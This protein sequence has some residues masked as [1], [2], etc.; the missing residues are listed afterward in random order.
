MNASIRR[1][2]VVASILFLA[3][4]VNVSVV[5][6]WRQSSLSADDRNRRVLDAEFA[7]NRG[8]I[9]AGDTQI[10][11]TSPVKDRFAYQRSYPQGSLYAT[12]TGWYAYDFGRSGLEAKY[13]TELAG[14]A[15]S[16]TIDR[17]VDLFTGATPVGATIQTTINPKLQ[18][19]AAQ[20]LSGKKGAVVALDPTTGAILAMVS[21]PTYDPNTLATHDLAAARAA[22]TTLNA[23][24]AR[25]LS[26]RGTREIYPPGSTFKLVT[27]AAALENGMTPDTLV[28]TP[29]QLTLPNS[30]SVL[31]NESNCG[32]TQQTLDRALQLSCNT[33]FAN[34]GATLG[35]DKIRAQAE[36]FGFDS[37][38]MT[39]VNAAKS[40]F[41]A[42]P[43]AA[44]T[45]L[46][47][48][49]QYDVAASPL[50]MAMVAA[51]ICDDGV[52][53]TPYLVSEVRGADLRVLYRHGTD[54]KRTMSA[55]SAQAL[56]QMMVN[57]V[58]K[59]TGTKAQ[60]PN[61]VVGGK[62]GTAQTDPTKNPYAWFVS[63]AK[64]P[65]IAIAVFIED[66]NVER[67][68]IA[69][70]ALAGPIAKAIIQA[71]R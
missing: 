66:A 64:N 23:D 33:A 22:W 44:Q 58:Q 8:A 38:P 21:T 32:N 56:Q 31:G 30:S 15:S 10:A 57:V 49:G 9:L 18:Q 62:T 3:L 53:K 55:A 16:Q 47:A 6:L 46:S 7:Q 42:K 26:D 36:K 11:T 48:I 50:Q 27:A 70:G 40:Q 54:D 1:T 13:S 12:V 39:D 68:E 14:T 41:P 4:L 25:P 28:D 63:F 60:V 52:L 59:G 34:V 17:L 45:M 19:V 37:T 61:V 29:S 65:D 43:D 24:P 71:S 51:A 20:Q 35:A 2:A 5:Q 69:G 67:N